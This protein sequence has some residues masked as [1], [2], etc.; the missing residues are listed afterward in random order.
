MSYEGSGGVQTKSSNLRSKISYII[1][2]I[3]GLFII[4]DNILY[5]INKV[6]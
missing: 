2:K 4:Y 3:R 1:K 5:N 6:R